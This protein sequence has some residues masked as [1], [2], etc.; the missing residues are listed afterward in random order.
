MGKHKYLLIFTALFMVVFLSSC[1]EFAKVKALDQELALV[2]QDLEKKLALVRQDLEKIEQADRVAEEKALQ[3]MEK[4]FPIA[5]YEHFPG[6]PNSADGVN[7]IIFWK[8]IS[9]KDI[10]YVTFTVKPFNAVD[11][12][13]Y[14]SISNKAD[15]KL[16]VTGPV[17]ARD[18]EKPDSSVWDNVW[19]NN[20]IERIEI[21]Q[22]DIIYMDNTEVSISASE[23]KDMFIDRYALYREYGVSRHQ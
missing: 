17:E 2:R 13:V 7:V 4:G 9:P 18:M 1:A 23:V 10:K 20:T 16:R 3:L 12:V 15:S 6:T 8:N 19:Y 5:I 14:C 11:D 21:V 22:I